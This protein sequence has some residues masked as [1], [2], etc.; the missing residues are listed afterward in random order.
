[1]SLEEQPDSESKSAGIDQSHN[2]M[3]IWT[4]IAGIPARTS[5]CPPICDRIGIEHIEDIH[6]E[7]D[8]ESICD[9][10]RLFQPEIQV[11]LTVVS[12]RP[13][14]FGVDR[15]SSLVEPVTCSSGIR[16]PCYVAEMSIEVDV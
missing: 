11:G 3:S 2:F 8:T 6:H 7:T 15:P 5:E 14:L 1:M 10:E 13:F 9:C 4:W 16:V 12:S